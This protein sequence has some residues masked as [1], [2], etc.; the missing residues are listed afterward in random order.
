MGCGSSTSVQEP[1]ITEQKQN[2]KNSCS[3]KSL[4]NRLD[5]FPFFVQ[6]M[7]VLAKSYLEAQLPAKKD[8]FPHFEFFGNLLHGCHFGKVTPSTLIILDLS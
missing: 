4:L 1:T 3:G 5:V 8:I 2:G 7:L 6:C